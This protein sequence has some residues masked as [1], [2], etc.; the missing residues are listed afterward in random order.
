MQSTKLIYT[1]KAARAQEKKKKSELFCD[2]P[3]ILNYW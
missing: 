1:A 2:R 3:L